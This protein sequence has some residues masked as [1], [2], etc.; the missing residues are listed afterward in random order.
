MP[1]RH[2]LTVST[3]GLND[4]GHFVRGCVVCITPGCLAQG[5]N[6][7]GQRLARRQSLQPSYGAFND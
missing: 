5:G 4:L 6:R 2:K 3:R 7:C 1:P